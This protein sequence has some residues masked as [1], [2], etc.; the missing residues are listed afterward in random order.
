MTTDNKTLPVF[1]FARYVN[2]IRMAEGVTIEK[3]QNLPE[4]M[5]TAAKLATIGHGG[6]VP[7]L[8]HEPSSL[9]DAQPGG[10]VR[11]GGAPWPEID[12]ILADAYSAGAEGLPF[13]GIARRAAVR[14]AIAALSAQP[15]AAE[16][17]CLR[18][19]LR[20]HDEGRTT[21][22]SLAS[23]VGDF[24]RVSAALSAQP[25][26]GGKDALAVIEELAELNRACAALDPDYKGP[27]DAA[28]QAAIAALAARQPVGEPMAEVISAHGDPEAFG[29]REIRVLADLRKIPYGTR[30]YAAPPAQAVDLPYS[31][32]AD[33]A[34]IRAR[35]ADV[36]TGTLMVGAQ[37][38]TPPPA[39]H[40]AE[41]FWQAAR[42]D[43]TA[44]GV[45][46]PAFK[47]LYRAY[48]R[49]LESGRDRIIDLGGTCDPVD[50]M[51]ANDVDLQVARHVLDS[52]AVGNG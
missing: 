22:Q 38:H 29:E 8:V 16:V 11:L 25:S 36:I 17:N 13:E 37:G 50:V 1:R 40:W 30:L 19:A 39:G 23:S 42:A 18:E 51:E 21:L 5:R 9:A 35:V 49:L 48:V 27:S 26:P 10:R 41:P 32:D 20:R 44:K 15:L 2:G 12:V 52:Q 43:A 34:G 47:A 28:V 24:L 33:P 45:D 3:A 6:D 14:K 7:V 4:A 31:L 46:L